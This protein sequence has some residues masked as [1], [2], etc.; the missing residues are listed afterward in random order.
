MSFLVAVLVRDP[1]IILATIAY[2]SFSLLVSF[3][4]SDGEK[5]AAVARAWARMLLRIGGVRIRLEGFEKLTPNTSYVFAA[6]HASYMDTPV[7]L[8]N[9]PA[10]FRF[11]ANDYLFRV[12][13]LGTHL[14]RAGHIPVAQG[15]AREAVKA[16]TEAAR[17]VRARQISVLVFP[18]GG[19]SL[20]GLQEF[21]DGA[22]YI[23][24]KAGI[25]IVPL[26]LKGTF[27]ILPMHSLHMK[28]G[29]VV[30]H[31]GEPIATTNLTIRDRAELTAKVRSEVARMLE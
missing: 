12:P 29:L 6:N 16:M 13:F 10:R 7:V 18:E 31:V 25:P 17:L 4:D 23:S 27:N 19:R 26:A 22:A 8:A 14:T 15:N 30:V 21:R 3:F 28:P 1:L 5:Q 11:L 24:I 20:T 9:I 2:G